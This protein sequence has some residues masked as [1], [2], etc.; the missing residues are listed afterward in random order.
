MMSLARPDRDFE[1]D[2]RDLVIRRSAIVQDTLRGASERVFRAY[3]DYADQSG[4]ATVLPPIRWRVQGRSSALF[5]NYDVFRG[6]ALYGELLGMGGARC[7]M[8]G[9]GEVSTLDHYLPRTTFPEFAILALNLVPACARCNQLKDVH[10]GLE[11]KDQ[12]FHPFFDTLEHVPILECKFEVQ[13]ASALVEFRIRRTHRV[14]EDVLA[15]VSFQFQKLRL[16]N[17]FSA[18]AL[19]EI[20]DRR[21]TFAEYAATKGA[22]GLRDYLRTESRGYVARH[23]PNYWKSALYRALARNNEFLSGGYNQLAL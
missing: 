11:P 9:F 3:R 10:V 15:K 20:G 1:Q 6:S 5:S 8:C 4:N 12:F 2:Y 19:A 17:R 18:E 22:A 14:A 23:G 16:A 7:P 13:A 21:T